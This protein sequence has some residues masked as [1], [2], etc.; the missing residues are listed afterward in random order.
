MAAAL[1][2]RAARGDTTWGLH[3]VRVERQGSVAWVLLDRPEVLN[4]LNTDV[5]LQLEAAF[6]ELETHRS[7]RAVVLAGSSPVFAAGADIAEMEK[8]SLAEGIE[9]GFLGQRVAERVERF[10][11]R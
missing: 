9:F 4:S 8:K 7:V 10:P 3:S 5:L 6:A 2:D 11:L 1:R